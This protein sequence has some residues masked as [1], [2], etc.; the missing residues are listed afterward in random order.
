MNREA[1]AKDAGRTCPFCRF[2]LKPG[3]ELTDC[4]VCSAAHHAECWDE[5]R[6]CAIALCAGGPGNEATR[7]LPPPPPPQFQPPPP[8][9]PP[10]AP[11]RTNVGLIAAIVALAVAV[12]AVA[13]AVVVTRSTSGA[14]AEGTVPESTPV[15]E[16]TPTETPEETE[17]ATPE[18][19]PE[20]TPTPEPTP[21]P[22]SNRAQIERI[23]VAYYANVL[24]GDYDGAWRL[25]SPTYRSWKETEGGGYAKWE[26]QEDV[27]RDRLDPSGLHVEI[28][29]IDG[30]VATID[31]S[32]M[33]M[34]TRNDPNCDF[35]G[36]TW[37][38]RVGGKWRYDQGYLQNAARAAEW[39]PRR[40][41]TLGYVCESDGY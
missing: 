41:Q 12:S 19:T 1:T 40:E 4:G 39:R 24:E 22:P 9:P 35:N 31:V 27:H 6:G 30:D 23:L 33:S 26:T 3:M 29:S 32:G 5:N 2:P 13:I 15:A 16:A 37:A 8:P 28:L 20:E 25:L 18:P 34:V 21:R 7:P 10:A 36:V 17:T 38:R 14:A 11:S